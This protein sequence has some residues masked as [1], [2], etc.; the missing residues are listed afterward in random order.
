[1]YS[2]SGREKFNAAYQGRE[3]SM[4]PDDNPYSSPRSFDDSPSN[5]VPKVLRLLVTATVLAVWLSIFLAD[6]SAWAT[7]A[8]IL[9]T[10]FP[11]VL[12]SWLMQRR[13]QKGTE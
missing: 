11:L 8:S 13:Q 10:G 6:L 1:M 9:A 2:V 3:I 7:F 4:P 5:L 12:L